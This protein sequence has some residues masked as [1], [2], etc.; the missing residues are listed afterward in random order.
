M[1]TSKSKIFKYKFMGSTVQYLWTSQSDVWFS[2][3]PAVPNFEQNSVFKCEILI[4]KF[5]DKLLSCVIFFGWSFVT[6]FW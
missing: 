5:R 1:W 4:C 3:K 6:F 2:M